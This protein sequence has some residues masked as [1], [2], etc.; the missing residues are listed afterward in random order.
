MHHHCG[1]DQPPSWTVR[2]V[3][4]THG[5]HNTYN[6]P[7]RKNTKLARP[8]THALS[9]L[10][11]RPMLTEDRFNIT[12]QET[13]NKT[14]PWKDWQ[15]SLTSLASITRWWFSPTTNKANHSTKGNGLSQLCSTTTPMMIMTHTLDKHRDE[16]ARQLADPMHKGQWPTG[17]S[18]ARPQGSL[19]TPTA[20]Q[21]QSCSLPEGWNNNTQLVHSPHST[22]LAVSSLTSQAFFLF[23]ASFHN[24]VQSL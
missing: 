13:G 20:W 17:S 24:T 15:H 21:H 16:H 5:T 1:T 7:S 23:F 9:K 18:G 12:T 8:L 6:R 10:N 14:E 2:I 3:A 4:I 22:A 11:S 19:T